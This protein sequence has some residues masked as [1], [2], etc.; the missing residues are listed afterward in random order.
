MRK[1]HD[2]LFD[3]PWG[4]GPP[5]E[6]SK[7][8]KGASMGDGLSA[9]RFALHRATRPVRGRGRLY[10][11]ETLSLNKEVANASKWLT[12]Q[13]SENFL[14]AENSSA[15]PGFGFLQQWARLR[16]CTDWKLIC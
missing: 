2:N 3:T 14:A 1:R 10:T 13:V 7:L 8:P 11:G 9:R 4:Y 16:F 12:C 15:L 6:I 5:L